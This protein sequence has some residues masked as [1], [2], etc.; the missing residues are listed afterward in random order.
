MLTQPNSVLA[1][2][3][4]SLIN[5]Y[6]CIFSPLGAG[7]IRWFSKLT[8]ILVIRK[9]FVNRILTTMNDSP[10]MRSHLQANNS[11][12]ATLKPGKTF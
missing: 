2:D 7:V 3:A 12:T 1:L 6:N 10:K 9:Q 11:S 8:N 4:L 5:E